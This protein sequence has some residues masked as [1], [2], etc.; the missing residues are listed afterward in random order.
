MPDPTFLYFQHARTIVNR[1]EQQRRKMGTQDGFIAALDQSGGSTPKALTQYGLAHD[2]WSGDEQMYALVHQMR[3]RIVTSP[4]FNGD[5]ILAAILFENT[6]DRAIEGM[7]LV[8]TVLE[9]PR[10]LVTAVASVR[11][12][13]SA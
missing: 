8:E 9:A 12:R 5:R 10:A 13:P 4:A 2:A 7:S 3:T 11:F 6:M 1:F